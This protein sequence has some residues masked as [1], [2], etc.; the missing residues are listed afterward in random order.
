VTLNESPHKTFDAFISY[1]H[2]ADSTLARRLQS[3]L[4]R[5]GKPWYVR[6]ALSVFRDETDLSA[7]PDGWADIEQALT[8][9]RY[10][11]LLASDT[12]ARSKWVQKEVMH[13]VSLGRQ[14]QLLIV[15]TAGEIVWSDAIPDFDWTRTT[16]LPAQI[17]GMFKQEPFWVNLKSANTSEAQNIRNP[18]FQLAVAKLAAPIRGIDPE[19]LIS[20][21][22]KEHRRTIRHATIGVSLLLVATISAL[23]FGLYAK[24]QR[25][26]AVAQRNLALVRQLAAEARLDMND[27]AE[28]FARS[29]LLVAESLKRGAELDSYKAWQQIVSILPRGRVFV[30]VHEAS[31][32]SVA[33][34]PSG[35]FLASTSS[36]GSIHLW[37]AKTGEKIYDVVHNRWDVEGV[38]VRFS[39]RLQYLIS[40]SKNSIRIWT[41]ASGEPVEQFRTTASI[42]QLA[43]S[44]TADV[45]IARD[46]A[47]NIYIWN[48]ADLTDASPKGEQLRGS[49]MALV[50]GGRLLVLTNA[51][52]D[53][54]TVVDATTGVKR[55]SVRN[56]ANIVHLGVDPSGE[57]VATSGADGSVRVWDLLHQKLVVAPLFRNSDIR[58]L[59]FDRSG[60]QIAISADSA[61]SVLDIRTGEQKVTI[62]PTGGLGNVMNTREVIFTND[63]NTLLTT[64]TES[65]FAQLWDTET[66]RERCR[67]AH[68]E[69]NTAAS[70]PNAHQ[71]A[72]GGSDKVVIVWST[73]CGAE[74]ASFSS[75]RDVNDAVF[76]PDGSVA[77]TSRAGLIRTWPTDEELSHFSSGIESQVGDSMVSMNGDLAARVGMAHKVRVW[78]MAD[79]H[80]IAHFEFDVALTNIRV[81][82]AYNALTALGSDGA[83]R[84]WSLSD[85]ENPITLRPSFPIDG[86]Q[87][88]EGGNLVLTFGGDHF[89]RLWRRRDGVELA[90][91]EHDAPVRGAYFSPASNLI[92]T[93]SDDPSVMLWSADGRSLKHVLR[94]KEE[95]LA[96][97]F[98]PS[99][100]LLA[101]ST[102]DRDFTLWNTEDGS[103]VYQFKM[104]SP[105]DQLL[106]SL[107]G[108]TLLVLCRHS[109]HVIVLDG[110]NASFRFQT[111]HGSEVK[112]MALSADGR[113][114][115]VTTEQGGASVWNVQNGKELVRLD[116]DERILKFAFSPKSDSF[117]TLANNGVV[118]L[119]P[120]A[121]QRLVRSVCFRLSRNL[122][123]DEWKRYFIDKPQPTCENI[124]NR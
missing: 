64:R 33:Y 31:V 16:A 36:D 93:R 58:Q 38:E 53:V 108:E 23:A 83:V 112:T 26:V 37:D 78:N 2:E 65:G 5:I 62:N 72:T 47:Q 1:S 59:E 88:S 91:M 39:E 35:K 18:Q 92:A 22:F 43:V 54:I 96:L 60:R 109:K 63:E 57:R 123:V 15:L 51:N 99:G 30:L 89:A 86:F 28:S 105:G 87:L 25:E 48:L 94:L 4:Q 102:D 34:S 106:F 104:D 121:S 14:K 27:S 69:L 29:A 100:N 11:I 56:G 110:H 24:S 97:A 115:G 80:E 114:M 61:V 90:A 19:T 124:G 46:E 44:A 20:Q 52:S 21:D 68:N 70:N 98:H 76:L 9:S 119:W 103:K 116:S 111:F 55:F 101:T 73:L 107:G 67:F 66:G 85:V 12:A 120:L 74:D 41:L 10:F 3:A 42:A 84:L 81:D 79:G 45:L 75:E 17:A 77:T 71:L 32:T 50:G 6:R 117:L 13:W 40:A 113:F 95:V 7:T 8:L 118:K 122:T 82:G 49:N